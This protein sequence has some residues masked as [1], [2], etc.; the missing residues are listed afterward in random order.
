MK[1][2]FV[3]GVRAL[4][5]GVA[6]PS[7]RLAQSVLCPAAPDLVP[8]ATAAL[9]RWLAG[10]GAGTVA[11][12]AARLAGRALAP[13]QQL[14][15]APPVRRALE[16]H[17]AKADLA[18]LLP[19]PAPSDT[20]AGPTEAPRKRSRLVIDDDSDDDNGSESSSGT[21]SGGSSGGGGGPS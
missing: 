5:V 19:A 7:E 11:Q 15:R 3:A 10:A 9:T 2:A 4:L 13:T 16:Q 8:V 18:A 1:P 6:A 17:L 14:L 21:G 20:P 12:A